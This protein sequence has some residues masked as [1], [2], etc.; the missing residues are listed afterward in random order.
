MQYGNV[1]W[2]GGNIWFDSYQ[3]RNNIAPSNGTSFS[4]SIQYPHAGSGVRHAIISNLKYSQGS[5]IATHLAVLLKA[6]SGTINLNR[7]MVVARISLASLP[8]SFT[9]PIGLVDNGSFTVGVAAVAITK[10]GAQAHGTFVSASRS[11]EIWLQA[12]NAPKEIWLGDP[13]NVN[14]ETI[15]LYRPIRMES[16]YAYMASYNGSTYQGGFSGDGAGMYMANAAGKFLVVTQG[17]PANFGF[18]TTYFTGLNGG[19]SIADHMVERLQYPSGWWRISGFFRGCRLVD[20]FKR[21]RKKLCASR[22][23]L[24]RVRL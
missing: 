22:A 4:I 16:P 18:G 11:P 8:S 1:D 23:A 15:R 3:Y 24:R 12:F 5:Y 13:N 20:D 14:Q 17:S 9:I 7:D 6:P 10:N 21:Q 19:L 2:A